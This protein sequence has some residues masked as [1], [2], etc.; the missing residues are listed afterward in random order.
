[1]VY[2][3]TTGLNS[4]PTAPVVPSTVYGYAADKNGTTQNPDYVAQQIQDDREKELEQYKQDH[5]ATPRVN[6][7]ALQTAE[8]T[9]KLEKGRQRTPPS[10]YDADTGLTQPISSDTEDTLILLD[11]S[12]KRTAAKY[13]ESLL[14]T[15]PPKT[16]YTAILTEAVVQQSTNVA[17]ALS[18]LETVVSTFEQFKMALQGAGNAM[19]QTGAAPLLKALSDGYGKIENTRAELKYL[20]T[21]YSFSER[22][23]ATTMTDEVK[24]SWRSW[25]RILSSYQ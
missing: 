18:D 8:Q 24:K 14:G 12:T 9:K 5:E 6:P 19:Y 20:Q 10:Y 7:E 25:Q 16:D 4:R 22:R 13:F 11:A 15:S 21:L 1:M 2:D 23:H 3:P 17:N